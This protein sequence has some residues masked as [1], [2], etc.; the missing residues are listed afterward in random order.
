MPLPLTVCCFTK[1]QTGFTFLVP[2]HPGSPGKRAVK[3]LKCYLLTNSV[4]DWS[5]D[6]YLVWLTDVWMHCLIDSVDLIIE[7][8]FP[9]WSIRLFVAFIYYICCCRCC[10]QVCFKLVIVLQTTQDKRHRF[11]KTWPIMFKLALLR[12]WLWRQHNDSLI[13]WSVHILSK[14]MLNYANEPL[15]ERGQICSRLLERASSAT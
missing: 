13:Q 5:A 14:I 4:L 2:A 9:Y 8:S 15:T 11:S 1:I 10:C 7:C 3:R 12:L 6:W